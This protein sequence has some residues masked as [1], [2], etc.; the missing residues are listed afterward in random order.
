M[1]SRLHFFYYDII[2]RPN[3]VIIKKM[4]G[5]IGSVRRETNVDLLAAIL[6]S[7]G[8]K[9]NSA[10]SYV[11]SA[12]HCWHSGKATGLQ[13]AGA[14][15]RTPPA[16]VFTFFFPTNLTSLTINSAFNSKYSEG[17]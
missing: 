17:P 11:H 1:Y 15:V 4:E 5:R 12:G 8:L 16:T 3:D 13:C 2:C 14:W 9:I 10:F 6:S 7:R